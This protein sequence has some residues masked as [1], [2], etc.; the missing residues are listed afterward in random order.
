VE[1]P[2]LAWRLPL[3]LRLFALIT[4][5]AGASLPAIAQPG[6][7]NFQP[8]GVFLYGSRIV[9]LI[10]TGVFGYAT[11]AFFSPQTKPEQL[12]AG[13]AERQIAEFVDDDEIVAQQ[14]LGQ[15]P[16]A[17]GRL[18]LFELVDQ[19][20]EVEE[21]ASGPGADDSG[22]DA[23]T[24]LLSLSAS[25]HR[26]IGHFR[27]SAQRADSQ[28]AQIQRLRAVGGTSAR[29]KIASTRF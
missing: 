19:I 13:L 3:S 21:P 29:S 27:K 4:I 11:G 26:S 15:P 25:T 14:L 18:F 28:A 10:L 22:G 12:T 1:R 5:A 2:Q 24:N 7:A 17:A 23:Q 20:D 16:A 9:Y 6:S 8:D